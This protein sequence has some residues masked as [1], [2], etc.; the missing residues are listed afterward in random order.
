MTLYM[1]TTF[2]PEDF[3]QQHF[4]IVS[5]SEQGMVALSGSNGESRL[6]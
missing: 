5:A 6:T 2:I 3:D 1:M 4:V